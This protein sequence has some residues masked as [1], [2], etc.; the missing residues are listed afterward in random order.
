MSHI[1]ESDFSSDANTLIISESMRD[2]LTTRSGRYYS[3]QI[4][5]LQKAIESVHEERDY[6]IL[7]PEDA[8]SPYGET[9]EKHDEEIRL[10][11]EELARAHDNFNKAHAS[12][13][14]LSLRE[15]I[16]NL[17]RANPFAE[18]LNTFNE[19]EM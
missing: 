12:H 6:L 15:K 1:P 10:L 18:L 5:R 2:F 11:E 9:V 7:R 3:A 13:N 4:Q 16:K 19:E 8:V 17:G 14:K